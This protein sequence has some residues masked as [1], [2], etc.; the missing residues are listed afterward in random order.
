[1]GFFDLFVCDNYSTTNF[2]IDIPLAV[3][4]FAIY[5]P[6]LCVLKSIVFV[7]VENTILPKLSNTSIL[8]IPVPSTL[9]IPVLL[10]FG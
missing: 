8:L 3:V 7:V 4:M 10:G 6:L 2:F 5:I 9:K 1:M